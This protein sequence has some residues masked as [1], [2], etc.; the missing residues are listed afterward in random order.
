MKT[1][2]YVRVSTDTQDVTHQR[3]AILGVCPH[4]TDGGGRLS[5]GAGLLTAL[6]QGA[7][8]RCLTTGAWNP[9]MPSL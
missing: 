6:G 5:G 8:T 3:L 9:G 2:A 4:G 7:P 1:V